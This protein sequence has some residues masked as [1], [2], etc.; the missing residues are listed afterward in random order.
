MAKKCITR[1]NRNNACGTAEGTS[2]GEIPK[3]G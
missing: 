1:R 2:G 3:A